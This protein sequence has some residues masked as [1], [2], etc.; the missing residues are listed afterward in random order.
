[1][2]VKKKTNQEEIQEFTETSEF[3]SKVEQSITVDQ[4]C[5]IFGLNATFSQVAKKKFKNMSFT[6]KE[7]KEKFVSQ[8]II[9]K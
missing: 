4:A 3:E 2:M 9:V 7:W 5:G 8:R 1:M 6:H